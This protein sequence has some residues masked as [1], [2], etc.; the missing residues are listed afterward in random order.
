MRTHVKRGSATHA[1]RLLA[2]PALALTALLAGC[3]GAKTGTAD[4]GAAGGY[5]DQ[6]GQ[7]IIENGKLVVVIIF[8]LCAI[9]FL[10]WLFRNKAIQILA[11]LGIGIAIA[12][13]VAKGGR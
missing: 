6:V 5:L 3:S 10:G 9:S 8:I 1:R 12:Y 4:P 11:A 13:F 2:A 7:F